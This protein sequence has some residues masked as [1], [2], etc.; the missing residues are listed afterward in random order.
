MLWVLKHAT[1]ELKLYFMAKLICLRQVAGW[2]FVEFF[3][4]KNEVPVAVTK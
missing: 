4:S 1:S 2:S 3:L